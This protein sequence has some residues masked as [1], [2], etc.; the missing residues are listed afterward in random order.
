[1]RVSLVGEGTYPVVRG[2]VGTWCD[3]LVRGLSEIDF[4]VTVLT[5]GVSSP[6]YSLPGNVR[7]VHAVDM[8]GAPPRSKVVR[9]RQWRSFLDA[10]A[11]IC[12]H[13]V[14]RYP[15]PVR[16][17]LEAWQVLA[18]PDVAERLWGMVTNPV[19]LALLELIRRRSGREPASARE[20]AG[21]AAHIARLVMPCRLPPMDVDLVHVTSSGSSML[22]ALQSHGQGI[23]I[24]LSEHGV[25]LRERLIALRGTEWSY[26]QRHIVASF[27][28]SVTRIGYEAAAVIAPVSDFNG[29]WAASLGARPGKITTVHNGVD[30]SVFR[31]LEEAPSEPILSFVGRIDPLKDLHTLVQATALVARRVPDVQ[32]YLIGPVPERNAHYA[33]DLRTLIAELGIAD[34][35]RMLGPTQDVAGAYCSGRIAVLSSVSEGFPYGALEPMACQRPVVATAVG[36][37]PEAVGDAGILVHS[38]DPQA[39]ADACVTLLEDPAEWRQLAERA[40]LRVEDLFTL[41]RMIQRFRDMYAR[42]ATGAPLPVSSDAGSRQATVDLREPVDLRGPV[43]LREPVGGIVPSLRPHVPAAR[44]SARRAVR[45]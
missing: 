43:D 15:V 14:G 30:T 44:R 23:P 18:R 31:P 25:F 13:A 37:V 21:A 2:G 3:Q 12:E 5:G 41:P 38:R 27:L 8:W 35:V 4:E 42:V 33:A 45:P 36:G 28:K 39:F 11:V 16:T 29:R 20:L 32:V 9:A 6:V 24:I 17:A 26:Q 40:R 1:M 7:S 10:W 22:A 19:S 34:R